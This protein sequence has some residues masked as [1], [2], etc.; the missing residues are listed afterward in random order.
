MQHFAKTLP[1][2]YERQTS[3]KNSSKQYEHCERE[4]HRII[5]RNN[6]LIF[7]RLLQTNIENRNSQYSEEAKLVISEVLPDTTIY[8]TYIRRHL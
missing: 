2:R 7:K 4:I 3:K 1:N 5:H 6:F 8:N